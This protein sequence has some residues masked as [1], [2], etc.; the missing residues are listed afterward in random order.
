MPKSINLGNGSVLIGLDKFGQ[1][2]DFYFHYPGLENHA[3]EYFTH[4]I[5]IYIDDRFSWLDDGSWEVKVGAQKETLASDINA[6]NDNLGIELQ[7]K[8]IVYN[9]KNIFIREI[10]CRNLFDRARKLKIYFNQQFDISQTH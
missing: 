5:G 6:K 2:K 10:T 4:K 7:F 1:V 3:G 9:E 8:D